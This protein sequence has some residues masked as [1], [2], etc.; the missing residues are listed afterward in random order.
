MGDSEGSVYQLG[1]G[2]NAGRWI[3]AV[4]IG[5]KPDGNPIRTT[6]IRDTEKACKAAL[7]A[8]L[9]KRDSG[10]LTRPS[11]EWTLAKWMPHWLNVIREDDDLA[12]STRDDYAS[13]T[14]V[15][16]IPQI[17]TVRLDKFTERHANKLQ[18][19]MKKAGRS[20]SRRH[21]AHVVLTCALDAAVRANLLG[22]NPLKS[23][24][25]P[26]VPHHVVQPPERA[27]VEAIYHAVR[28]TRIEARWLIALI[29][30]LRQGEALGLEWRHVDLDAMTITI[31]QQQRRIPG[32][33]GCGDPI[34]R[35]T[36]ENPDRKVYTCGFRYASLCTSEGA[37]PGGLAILRVKTT[38]G[39]RTLPLTDDIVALLK[40]LQTQQS[41]DRLM[42]G[43]A[44]QQWQKDRTTGMLSRI[45][46]AQPKKGQVP[47]RSLFCHADGRPIDGRIDLEAWY[48]VL[49][50]AG[51]ATARDDGSWEGRT[52]L[53]NAR[54]AAA[55]GMIDS[56]I[57]MALIGELLGHADPAFSVRIYGH[58]ST[59]GSNAA[60]DLLA[61]HHSK[62]RTPATPAK[63]IGKGQR[64]Q[65]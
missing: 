31:E 52:R 21:H 7:R 35:P 53:H 43:A 13:L 44:Y 61:A 59:E 9:N 17:G 22:Y 46:P 30:G 55:V 32:H 42:H 5:W 37:T 11:K 34:P 14:R 29:L 38:K 16:I 3:G 56:G 58:L 19:A 49:A 40:D 12:I 51:L 57:P 15:W 8:V 36:R 28:G 27:D 41:R 50:A 10:E 23:V 63:T 64:K 6:R 39:N 26:A 2:P 48:D 60:R 45:D 65:P 54:H 33:H 20:A 1:T 62:M 47:I 4:V 25:P 18:A 24:K